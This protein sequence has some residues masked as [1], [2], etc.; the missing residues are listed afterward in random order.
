M[1]FA[2]ISC[3]PVL[4]PGDLTTVRI[5]VSVFNLGNSDYVESVTEVAETIVSY[6]LDYVWPGAGEIATIIS[7]AFTNYAFQS[8]DGPVVLGKA[9]R[10]LGATYINFVGFTTGCRLA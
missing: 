3:R 9:A 4:I 5:F 10:L 6:A 2:P 7:D 1:T 8:C